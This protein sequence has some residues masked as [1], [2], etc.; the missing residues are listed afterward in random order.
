MTDEE[1]NKVLLSSLNALVGDLGHSKEPD[2]RQKRSGMTDGQKTMVKNMKQYYVYILASDRNGTFYVGMTSDLTKRVYEHKE[3]LVEGF[4]KKYQVAMLVYFE[5]TND[6]DSAIKREKQL[7]KWNR[8][9]K[10]RLI[11]NNNPDWDDL[12][13]KLI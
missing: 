4:T 11:E 12:Y 7:K 10:L 6:A 8:S 5:I 2:V 9:W 3:K 1:K 13:Y